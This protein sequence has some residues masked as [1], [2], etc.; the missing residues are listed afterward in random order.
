MGL[1]LVILFVLI[2]AL[3]PML[4]HAFMANPGLDGTI[5][6]VLIIGII[7]NI[8]LAWRLFPEIQW[9]ERL[10]QDRSGLVIPN[11]PRLLAPTARLFSAQSDR[12]SRLTLSSQTTSTLLDSLESRLDEGREISRY[13]T[14]LL[15]FLGLL[16]TFYGLLL[17]VR[18]IADVIGGMSVGGSDLTAMFDHVKNGLVQPL[19]GMATAFSGS[20]FGLAGALVL[21]FLDLTAGQAQTRFFNDVE[22]WFADLTNAEK[23]RTSAP[24]SPADTAM[25]T[26][27]I[28]TWVPRVQDF[29]RLTT[30]NV[31]LLQQNISMLRKNAHDAEENREK[32]LQALKDITK[33]ITEQRYDDPATL[34]LLQQIERQLAGLRGDLHHDTS[35]PRKD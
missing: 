35:R 14:Q 31:S 30:E 5:I 8:H 22:E 9:I 24:H 15:V 19:S 27:T 20:M 34:Q 4:W 17:T 33:S 2:Y 26:E 6:A 13:I 10:R 12:Q 3:H 29:M 28:E 23:I 18:S 7:W 16:G 11:P 25:L 1:F 21:G 32:V